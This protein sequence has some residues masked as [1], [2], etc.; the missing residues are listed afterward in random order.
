M[1]L[2]SWAF[3]KRDFIDKKR[4]MKAATSLLAN[5]RCLRSELR[6]IIEV[7]VGGDVP[8]R[9]SQ[10]TLAN[11]FPALIYLSDPLTIRVPRSPNGGGLCLL[12]KYFGFVGSAL[13]LL[14]IGSVGVSTTSHGLTREFASDQPSD[15][16]GK[17]LPERVNIDT[18]LPTIAPH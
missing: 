8:L 11:P 16:I 6:R 10:P 18:S 15:S 13:V 1:Q 12:M 5:I 3:S 14:L 17:Q 2:S 7:S 4:C 9:A